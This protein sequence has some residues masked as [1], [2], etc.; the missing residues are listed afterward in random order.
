M[1]H[2][3]ISLLIAK[4]FQATINE[5]NDDVMKCPTTPEEWRVPYLTN[6][7]KGGPKLLSDHQIVLGGGPVVYWKNHHKR[8]VFFLKVNWHR[9]FLCLHI[10]FSKCYVLQGLLNVLYKKRKIMSAVFD[11]T[12]IL[13]VSYIWT[14]RNLAGPPDFQD[15]WS[16][17]P[18]PRNVNF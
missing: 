3:T 10:F 5:Y 1:P 2:N 7:S 15:W 14:T 18:L 12:N 9:S 6:S 13:T 8:T 17:G 11:L 16:D 4:V